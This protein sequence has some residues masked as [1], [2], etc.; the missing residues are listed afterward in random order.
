MRAIFW[1]AAMALVIVAVASTTSDADAGRGRPPIAPG[2][3]SQTGLYLTGTTD[4][5]PR[6]RPYSPQYPLWTDGAKKRRWI[7]LPDGLAIDGRD[8][9]RWAFP[10]GTKFW[11]E[12][13]FGSRRVETRF[14]WR[15]RADVWI[16]ASYVWNDQQTDAVLA[17]TSGERDVAD[18][19][20][21]KRHSVPSIEDCH[22]C[23]DGSSVLGFTALQLSPDRDPLAPHAEPLEPEM[24][25]MQ[26][27]VDEQRLKPP[28]PDLVARPPRIQAETP[29]ARAAL[30]YLSANCGICHRDGAPIDTRLRLKA[31]A[32]GHI[33]P[34]VDILRSAAVSWQIPSA[35]EGA[36]RFVAPGH[37]EQSSILIRMTSRRPST[38]M[39]P[40]GT[41]T[42]D[43]EATALIEAWIRRLSS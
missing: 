7:R 3:L 8:D 12:F 1:A 27:L 14:I 15:A 42:V 11:K 13:A 2:L 34:V 39:P 38:Q 5:D 10:V 24:L 29:T 18:L 33:A 26:A 16:F 21:G 30:G 35:G 17:S 41:V 31:S 40:L 6:N 37:P 22:A 36:T 23:H 25:T 4:I 20:N 28:R 9:E 43:H 19:G 32:S